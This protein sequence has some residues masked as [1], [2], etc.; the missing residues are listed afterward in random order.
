MR[1]HLGYLLFPAAG[2]SA[3][4]ASNVPPPAARGRSARRLGRAALRLVALS[5][6]FGFGTAAASAAPAG[7]IVEY[8]SGLGSG[9]VPYIIASGP[10]GNVW[11]TGDGTTHAVWRITPSGQITKFSTGLNA[12]SSPNGIATGPD[13]NTWFTDLGTTS[14]IGRITPSGQI[15]EFSSGLEPNS[16]PWLG[17]APGPDGNIWFADAGLTPAI[18]RISPSGQITEFPGSSFVGAPE[19]LAPGA[20]GNLWFTDQGLNT[21]AVGSVGAGAPA[22]SETPPTVTGSGQAGKPQLCGGEVWTSWAGAQPLLG[23]FPFDGYQWLL[24]GTPLSAQNGQA[25]TPTSSQ[26]G[27]ALSCRLTVTYPIPL[28]VTEAATSAPIT[29]APPSNPITMS[30]P[31]TS[32]TQSR[33]PKVQITTAA[34]SSKRRSAS[35]RFKALGKAFGFR[36]ALTRMPTGRHN[37]KNLNPVFSACRSPRRYRH[38]TAGRYVFQVRALSGGALG[39]TATKRFTIA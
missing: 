6:V 22:A 27:H 19:A 34:I 29:V 11:F 25:Y 38:L 37:H 1:D 20:D 36:C 32:P 15:T 21:G 26:V 39:S 9:A 3:P 16:N 24:D 4:A 14:A 18:G 5:I 12:G 10:D 7:Q 2:R 31:T 13:G 28:F 33:P 30:S 17:I 23:P 8:S 35:F